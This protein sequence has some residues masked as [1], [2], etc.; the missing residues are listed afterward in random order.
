MAG[1]SQPVG[2]MGMSQGAGIACNVD[3]DT[4]AAAYCQ[5]K[6]VS[7]TPFR[8]AMTIIQCIGD[9]GSP[10][11]TPCHS[12]GTPFTKACCGGSKKIEGPIYTMEI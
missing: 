9:K 7:G 3:K 8:I 1:C 11:H 6:D 4:S 12:S 5:D 10:C 2:N